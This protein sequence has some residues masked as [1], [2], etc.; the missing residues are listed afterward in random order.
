[1][2]PSFHQCSGLSFFKIKYTKHVSRLS[3]KSCLSS[4]LAALFKT[5]CVLLWTANWIGKWCDENVVINLPK[6]ME[7]IG[8]FLKK[9]RMSFVWLW[10]DMSSVKQKTFGAHYIGFAVSLLGLLTLSD[11]VKVTWSFRM[12]SLTYNRVC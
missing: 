11:P 9:R 4:F 1:M 7:F 12:I 5:L 8:S 10:W 6:I 3:L 2:C